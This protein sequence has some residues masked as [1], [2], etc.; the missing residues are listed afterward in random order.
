MQNQEKSQQFNPK[1]IYRQ[2]SLFLHP[3][4]AFESNRIFSGQLQSTMNQIYDELNGGGRR[5]RNTREQEQLEYY[6]KKLFNKLIALELPQKTGLDESVELSKL[7][8][9][10]NL[11]V[12]Y[13]PA[14]LENKKI[15]TPESKELSK[16]TDGIVRLLS[17]VET[18]GGN[19]ESKQLLEF[20]KLLFNGIKEKLE[21]GA[22]SEVEVNNLNKVYSKC[23]VW[24]F[25]VS[26]RVKLG[27]KSVE[28]LLKDLLV[29]I[30]P[31][32]YYSLKNSTDDD[33]V[34]IVEQLKIINDEIENKNKPKTEENNK[35]YEY[36]GYPTSSSIN[37][38]MNGVTINLSNGVLRYYKMPQGVSIYQVNGVTTYRKN[39]VI[40]EPELISEEEAIRLGTKK[41][42]IN[43]NGGVSIGSSSF[44]YRGG[45]FME[46]M[47]MGNVV[48]GDKV[49]FN[50]S[51]NSG[52]IE[53]GSIINE[54]NHEID[55]SKINNLDIITGGVINIS[56]NGIL[57]MD[58]INGGTVNIASGVTVHL[59][60]INDG[61][62]N[63]T[64][65]AFVICSKV[66]GG[67]INGKDGISYLKKNGG[68]IN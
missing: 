22:L 15:Q 66:N 35:K 49:S 33:L 7:N 5:V 39:G 27:E 31:K 51:E 1:L 41:P 43:S 4:G 60:I 40:V 9:I 42:T 65:G 52:P 53:N 57:K 36:T 48:I 14:I 28:D 8:E 68:I 63:I 30:V 25:E 2:V 67:T 23:G 11:F 64:S 56:G 6:T 16:N 26:N 12:V 13:A 45:I 55:V 10:Q 34:K 62:V 47:V 59:D 37:M 38:T 18:L 32:I 24:L 61:V 20:I 54:G 46:D 29:N 58:R 17:D 19:Q 50:R 21:S 3:D 44:N